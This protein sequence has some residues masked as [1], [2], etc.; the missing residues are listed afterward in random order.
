MTA[1]MSNLGL[2]YFEYTIPI[3]AKPSLARLIPTP[4]DA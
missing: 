2:E 1:N 4:I 3:C